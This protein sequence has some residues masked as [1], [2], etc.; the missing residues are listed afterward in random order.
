M[1]KLAKLTNDT[2]LDTSSIVHNKQK[3][4]KILNKLII[5]EEALDSAISFDD[6]A[7]SGKSS[8]YVVA[9]THHTTV[10][11]PKSAYNYGVIITINPE[12]K[13]KNYWGTVQI[14]IPDDPSVYGIY[15]RTSITKNW[16][17]LT[18][19]AINPIS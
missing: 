11:Y 13:T 1:S 9:A 5:M 12:A 7:L 18:G 3:L 16:V 19:T 4:N 8:A 10:G 15:F 2:Y 14:Y 17:K 6:L